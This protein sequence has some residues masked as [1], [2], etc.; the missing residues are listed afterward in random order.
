[1]WIN[2]LKCTQYSVS[3]AQKQKSLNECA[4][5]TTRMKEEKKTVDQEDPSSL[6]AL[7]DTKYYRKFKFI[8]FFVRCM[9]VRRC[10]LSHRKNTRLLCVK[11]THIPALGLGLRSSDCRYP[12]TYTA[13]HKHSDNNRRSQRYDFQSRLVLV[14]TFKCKLSTRK[15]W[16]HSHENRDSLPIASVSADNCRCVFNRTTI[17]LLFFFV[18]MKLAMLLP[19]SIS[20]V[21]AVFARGLEALIR[22]KW[23]KFRFETGQPLEI[24]SLFHRHFFRC[25]TVY[26]S[27]FCF[28]HRWTNRYLFHIFFILFNSIWH[29]YYDK[30]DGFFCCVCSMFKNSTE[31]A[32][33]SLLSFQT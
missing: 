2:K 7:A 14:Y 33:Q 15:Q 10:R 16:T 12:Y 4:E 6:K 20:N 23:T 1:M 30:F 19:E 31:Q 25:Y 32:M 8:Y 29:D 3:I 21:F 13:S 26:L 28:I 11:W 22:C 17:R 24:H 9:S 27:L 18:S 5:R